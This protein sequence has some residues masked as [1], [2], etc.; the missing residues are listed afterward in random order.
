MVTTRAPVAKVAARWRRSRARPT[1]AVTRRPT[2]AVPAW[3]T[4]GPTS[5][6]RPWAHSQRVC[7]GS[8]SQRPAGLPAGS[9]VVGGVGF[10]WPPSSDEELALLPVAEVEV[11]LV[12][13]VGEG[14]GTPLVVGPREAHLGGP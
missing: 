10:S 7:H 1:T 2:A 11:V 4:T 3:T 6:H 13:F 14:T 8:A 5:C 12:V 9:D